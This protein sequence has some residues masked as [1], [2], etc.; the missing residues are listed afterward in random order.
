MSALSLSL[1]GPFQASLDGQP[2]GKFRT[3]KVQALL[4]YLA[5]EASVAVTEVEVTHRREALMALLWPGLLP[6]S[7]QVNLRY[8]LYQLRQAIPQ[9][10]DTEG[11]ENVPLLLSDRQTVQI[12][13]AADV[14]LDV[15]RFLNLLT[16]DPA[17]AQLTEAVALYRGD[18][19]CDFFLP[20]SAEF[21][22]WAETKRAEL[23]RRTLGALEAL[24]EFHMEQRDYGQ[25][26]T[27]AWRALEI[28]NLRE[29][30]YRGLMTAL[31]LDGQRE[32]ALVQ[33]QLCR[34]R[35]Q[36]E[37][38]AEP[39]AEMMTLV[40]K[41]RTGELETELVEVSS[42]A[43]R[44]ACL[45]NL[46]LQ[47]TPLIGR[48]AEL[49]DLDWLIADPG[50]RL[51]TILGPGG[52]GKTRLALALAERQL[53]AERHLTGTDSV[54]DLR[55]SSE[56]LFP[57]GVFFVS[58]AR[59][60]E[61]DQIVPSVAEAL[62]FR[63]EG[64]ERESRTPEREES[65]TPKQ[66]VLD[67]LREKR[68]LLVLDNFEH[69]LP[70]FASPLMGGIEGAVELVADILRTARQVQL[71]V[72]SR[73]RLH[74]HE[75][76][77]YPIQGLE[78]PDWEQ[79][80]DARLGDGADYAAAQLF[81]QAARRIQP[82]FALGG[83]DVASLT[84]I[85]RLLEGM[86]LGIELAASWVDVLPLADI[87]DEIQRGLD[88][89]ERE[90]RDVPARH[91][92]M[93]AVFDTSWRRLSATEQNAFAQLCVFR[94]GF[95]RAAARAVAGVDLRTLAR[96][97]DK[98]LLQSSTA[99]ERYQ[100]HELLRQYGAGKL[101]QDPESEAAIRDRHSAFYCAALGVW[102]GDIKGAR[103]RVALAEIEADLEN[104]RSAWAWAVAH[105]QVERL[106]QAINGLGLVY[107]YLVQFQNGETSFT[108][109]QEQMTS[110]ISQAAM[111]T[112]DALRAQRVLAK[113]MLWR[114]LFSFRLGHWELAKTL[115]EQSRALLD[116]P[117]LAD[118]DTRTERAILLGLMR[119]A[120]APNWEAVR[121]YLEESLSLFQAVG[122]QWNAAWR[123]RWLGDVY[124]S[125]GDYDQ[126]RTMFEESLA[127]F[128]ALGCLGD[129]S[130]VLNALGWWAWD[131]CDY[132]RAKRYYKE[133]L[134][135][136]QTEDYP[137]RSGT[138][139][140]NLGA[141]ALFQG[142]FETAVSYLRKTI[143]ICREIGIRGVVAARLSNLA[144]AFWLS[145]DFDQAY[146]TIGEGMTIAR[147]LGTH[148]PLYLVTTYH[149]WLEASAGK[150]AEAQTQAQ[151]ALALISVDMARSLFGLLN[152][153]LAWVALAEERY[154]EAQ[155]PLQECIAA[156]QAIGDREFE[157][158]ALAALG[159]AEHG[160]ENRAKAGQHLLEAL[161][162]VVEIRGFIPLLYLMPVIPVALVEAGGS[163]WVEWAVELYAMAESH[164]YVAN[165]Q[166][167]ADIAGRYVKAAAA[168][169]L[170]PEVVEL[171]QK[172]GQALDWWETAEE[173]LIELRELGWDDS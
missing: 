104:V 29:S 46:P 169:A 10:T 62:D 108:L 53:H 3:S 163:R 92:S 85:C 57:N 16:P 69:L 161:E 164:P 134:A 97:V 48:E 73:E 30:A 106:D 35:L 64:D 171:A 99:R 54:G 93:R 118:Q 150:Y 109:A 121:R 27:Y 44:P 61:A 68:M 142:H 117:S 32:A 17:P 7:A 100:F 40:E 72:T 83:D 11:E 141:L 147:E 31:A 56:S 75:E 90:W 42:A 115:V 145:G 114:S 15:A 67:Y 102:E 39:T 168:A 172:R 126:A 45:H 162:I 71:L 49:A 38:S 94:G 88:F 77:A 98:S 146:V 136:S 33:Y 167:F 105:I 159:R 81:L 1:L 138:A 153:L 111:A 65:R 103:Q 122:D 26:Q 95:T 107:L 158:W 5:T 154:A 116:N 47:P 60:S 131:I 24:T 6:K 125:L 4:I 36:A 124:R 79:P 119:W 58:L 12:N 170:P 165:G 8:T 25:A 76:Q 152:G 18:F 155:Q 28:D 135:L 23:R 89:L 34:K 37:L 91:R 148:W 52:I 19:L 128:R 13:P 84:R 110:G 80:K 51:V 21:E 120:A 160:L 130:N 43:Q 156:Y 137:Y 70:P 144:A 129:A 133:S 143:A 157:A 127:S 50:V 123:A 9:V 166:L 2:L 66:Q 173:L 63:F 113:V 151:S 101:A 14:Q 22:D 87:A 132:D 20:D 59:L 55:P 86:P 112:S 74:L 82:G 149:A 139:L 41:I 140:R 96:L 78:Y